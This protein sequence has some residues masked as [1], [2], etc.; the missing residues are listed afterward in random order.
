VKAMPSEHDPTAKTSAL[1]SP[2]AGLYVGTLV[3]EA[4]I[5][6]LLWLLGRMYP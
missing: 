2:L 6:V 1:E 4:V 3:V 5:I